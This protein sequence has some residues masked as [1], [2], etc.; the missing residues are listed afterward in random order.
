[1]NKLKALYESM[2][3]DERLCLC[4]G[5]F[6]ARLEELRLTD[7]EIAALICLSLTEHGMGA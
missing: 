2:D 7:E 5:L 6:P 3:C 1:M 4:F